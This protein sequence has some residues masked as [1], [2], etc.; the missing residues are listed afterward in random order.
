MTHSITNKKNNLLDL[1]QT[2]SSLFQ[3]NKLETTLTLGN[4]SLPVQSFYG[5]SSDPAF[6]LSNFEAPYLESKSEG[7]LGVSASYELENSRFMIGTSNPI[8]HNYDA[9][10]LIESGQSIV[11]SLEYDYSS[12]ASITL[13]SGFT[14]EKDNLLGLKGSDAFSTLGAKSSTVFSALKAQG[15]IND[16]LTLTGLATIARTNMSK[17]ES[18]LL[19][20][21]AT[22]SLQVLH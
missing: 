9:D 22:L 2:N 3:S 17:P 10:S 1:S 20:L 7:S 4:S 5:S 6:D 21:Q 11:A 14:R 12:D 13:M 15:H 19:N 8:R 16:N 18:V